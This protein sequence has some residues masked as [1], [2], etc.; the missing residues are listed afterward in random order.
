MNGYWI[1]AVVGGVM[2]LLLAW[3]D[4]IRYICINECEGSERSGDGLCRGEEETGEPRS[5]ALVYRRTRQTIPGENRPAG[6]W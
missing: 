4:V 2:A 6:G 1:A 3:P 5:P